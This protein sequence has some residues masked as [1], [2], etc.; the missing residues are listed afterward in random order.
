MT[1]GPVIALCLAKV[2]AIKGWRE[3]MGPTD[4]NKARES[5]PKSLRALF[6]TDGRRNACHGSDSPQSA[7]R[8]IKF[9]FPRIALD[10]V[11]D[12][13]AARKYLN[14]HL[15]K[16][17]TEGLVKLSKE[18]PVTEPVESI[19]VRTR[20]RDYRPLRGSGRVSRTHR[21]PLPPHP[22]VP[23]SS[24]LTA[25]H[26][27]SPLRALIQWMIEFLLENNP[28]RPKIRMVEELPLEED[29]E[30]EELALAMAEQAELEKSAVKIQSHIRGK[31]ARKQLE[32]KKTALEEEKA[33]LEELERAAVR[34]QAVGRGRMARKQI[35]Q[36]KA[37]IKKREEE[38]QHTQEVLDDEQ[39]AIDLTVEKQ[40]EQ[41]EI[42]AEMQGPE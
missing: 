15:S 8:E 3:L 12:G 6:G 1:S 23:P 28:R 38:I 18:R 20:A 22:R 24:P 16:I 31:I 25:P 32:M 14:E 27:S 30:E 9:F 11:P 40:K 29:D 5:A 42:E 34:I 26:L 17:L 7:A 33:S 37:D 19:E 41:A 36:M 21:S 10:T 13:E 4:S 35:E 2:D 39:K